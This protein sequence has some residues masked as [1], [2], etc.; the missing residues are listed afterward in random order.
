MFKMYYLKI[1][2]PS[3]NK[4]LSFYK[5]LTFLLIIDSGLFYRDQKSRI[6]V[7]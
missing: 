5:E 2:N 3:F 4:L 6:P 1:E 7:V